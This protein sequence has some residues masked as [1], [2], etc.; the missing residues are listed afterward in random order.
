[1]RISELIVL[2]ERVKEERGD[3]RVDGWPYDG[4]AN[5][6]NGVVAWISPA[7]SPESAL[8]FVEPRDRDL[9]AKVFIHFE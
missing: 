9:P 8:E 5:A 1:M 3:I 2:L 6:G 7:L 4:Q